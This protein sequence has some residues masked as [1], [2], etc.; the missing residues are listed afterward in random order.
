MPWAAVPPCYMC[1]LFPFLSQTNIRL[2]ENDGAQHI[3]ALI[4]FLLLLQSLKIDKEEGV[5]CTLEGGD[6]SLRQS[7]ETA[8]TQPDGESHPT[9][10]GG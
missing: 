5:C 6:N 3:H 8:S 9:A 1:H 7:G 2:T 4:I 10:M